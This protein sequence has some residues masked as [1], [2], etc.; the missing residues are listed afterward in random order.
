MTLGNGVSLP[1]GN[2][3]LH[4][5]FGVR[6]LRLSLRQLSFG[7]IKH[8]LKGT[9]VDLKEELTLFD[10]CAFVII[11]ANQVTAHL[12]LNLRIDVAFERSHPLALNGNILL[13]DLRDFDHGWWRR[14]RSSHVAI[15]AAKCMEQENRTNKTCKY[16]LHHFLPL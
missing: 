6:H 7:L 12:R 9:G 4:V 3:P 13:N 10:E 8:G 11:L 14:G 1:F 2:I 16:L 15:A 5:R